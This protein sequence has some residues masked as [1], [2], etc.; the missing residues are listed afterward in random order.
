MDEGHNERSPKSKTGLSCYPWADN[1]RDE[2]GVTR[3]GGGN[4]EVDVI[5]ASK[6]EPVCDV[7][8]ESREP[9]DIVEGEPTLISGMST[10][11]GS[12]NIV[13][14]ARV[15]IPAE[16]ASITGHND[17]VGGVTRD[18]TR[19]VT[20]PKCRHIQELDMSP[21]DMID[22]QDTVLHI[23]QNKIITH[24]RTH[25]HTHTRTHTHIYL[26]I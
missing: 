8:D 2:T 23:I 14:L 22:K 25:I 17:D 20:T 19:D 16:V 15:V 11:T 18:V 4:I 21:E 26:H 9:G 6:G 10:L 13:P 5:E 1:N 3:E 12:T 24:T 7:G